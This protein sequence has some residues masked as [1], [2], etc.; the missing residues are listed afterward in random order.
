MLKN[1][2][3]LT[4]IVSHSAYPHQHPQD[5][6]PSDQPVAAPTSFNMAHPSLS[7]LRLIIYFQN[8]PPDPVTPIQFLILAL[9]D[10][11]SFHNI[12]HI[13]PLDTIEMKISGIEFTTQQKT[14]L[15][16]P[17]KQ[18]AI[19]VAILVQFHLSYIH[20]LQYIKNNPY[21]IDIQRNMII[22]II[23]INSL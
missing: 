6:R 4:F 23:V 1:Q 15:F 8:D 7:L 3:K 19:I 18:R 5:A 9:D 11:E 20:F 12:I 17:T 2:V 10:R 22:L 21:F 14:A 16:I 13:I